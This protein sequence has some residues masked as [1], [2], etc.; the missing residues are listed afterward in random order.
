MDVKKNSFYLRTALLSSFYFVEAYLNGV[1]Y[2]F[3]YKNEATLSPNESDLLLE[4][5]SRRNRR[6]LVSFEKK[7]NEYP[8]II[9]NRQ[10]PPI[11][12]TSSENLEILLGDGKEMRDSLVHQSSKTIDITVVPE[13]VKWM[14]GIGFNEVTRVVDAAVGFV[15]EMNDA[16]GTKGLPLDWMYP[17]Q[18]Q[19]GMFPPQAFE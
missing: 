12:V 16:L 6:G 13:K 19:S 17:R 1:A 11:T 14:L 9:L 15:Q 10:H 7:I 2:D 4:W 3:Y 8:K 5:D 18:P